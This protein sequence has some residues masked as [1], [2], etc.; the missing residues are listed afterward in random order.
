M[1]LFFACRIFMLVH[2]DIPYRFHPKR[3]VKISKV[4]PFQTD[5]LHSP[6]IFFEDNKKAC[7]ES[8]IRYLRNVKADSCR[9]RPVGASNST[10]R[11]DSPVSFAT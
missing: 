6:G 2:G 4:A 11:D 9:F 10:G 8:R 5:P 1:H 7:V 3:K